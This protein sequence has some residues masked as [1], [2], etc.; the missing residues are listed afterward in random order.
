[1][2]EISQCLSFNNNFYILLFF[3]FINSAKATNQAR[4]SQHWGERSSPHQMTK[5]FMC[6]PLTLLMIVWKQLIKVC[7]EEGLLLLLF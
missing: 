1:M 6:L 5:S 7:G 2:N 4:V 3:Y